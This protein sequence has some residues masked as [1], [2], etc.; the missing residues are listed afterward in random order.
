MRQPTLVFFSLVACAS[1]P[2]ADSKAPADSDA[3]TDTGDT[4]DTAELIDTAGIPWVE[5]PCDVPTPN[6]MDLYV[7]ASADGIAWEPPLFVRGLASVPEVLVDSRIDGGT[8]WMLWM[9]FEDRSD[10]C[11]QLVF[12]PIN[13]ATGEATD[14]RKTHIRDAPE[15]TLLTHGYPH[16]VSDP[17]I[18]V[19]GNRI[20]LMNTIW[21]VGQPYACAGIAVAMDEGTMGAGVF[22]YQPHLL[23]CDPDHLEALT[24]P[25]GVWVPDDRS[26]PDSAGVIRVWASS[27]LGMIGGYID[28]MEWIVAVPDPNDPSTWTTQELRSS[29]LTEFHALG[30]VQY[31]GN[32]DCMYAMWGTKDPWVHR[33]CTSDFETWSEVAT[34][35][36][37]SADPVVA[38]ADGAWYMYVTRDLLYTGEPR[39]E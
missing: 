39:P 33:G 22:A 17:D 10:R 38:E 1:P 29:P 35:D 11:D 8:P 18:T 27:S 6:F 24:D 20:V 32:T 5:E 7:H 25:L 31:V 9:D 28:N 12:S 3:V 19:V 21:P 4:G 26:D 37:F 23:W 15:L 13:P 30:S 2:A 36:P 34:P 14:V 16:P